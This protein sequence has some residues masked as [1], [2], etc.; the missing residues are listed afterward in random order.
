MPESLNSV[1]YLKVKRRQRE[2][3]FFYKNN[4]MPHRLEEI[5]KMDIHPMAELLKHPEM[6]LGEFIGMSTVNNGGEG[7]NHKKQT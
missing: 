4:K 7:H 1:P 5:R 6:S 3:D 2:R